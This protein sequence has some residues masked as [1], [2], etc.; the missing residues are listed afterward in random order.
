M[1]ATAEVN[2]PPSSTSKHRRIRIG[3]IAIDCTAW[4]ASVDSKP[5]DLTRSELDLLLYLH[6]CRHRTV[7]AAE[8]V[9]EVLGATGADANARFHVWN[10]RRKL[11]AAGVNGSALVKTVRG[12]GYTISPSAAFDAHRARWPSA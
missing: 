8:I 2:P 5:L 11:D 3:P 7:S 4:R 9:A 10:L 1:Q 6:N 12:K